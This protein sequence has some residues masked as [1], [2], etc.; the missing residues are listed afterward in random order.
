[1]GNL[2]I[3]VWVAGDVFREVGERLSL[4]GHAFEGSI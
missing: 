1:M 3:R 4:G 2:S